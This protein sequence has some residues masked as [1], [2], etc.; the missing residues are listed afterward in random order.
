MTDHTDFPYTR[1]PDL[2]YAVVQASGPD[3]PRNDTASVAKLANGDLMVVWHK[4]RTGAQGSSD[5]GVCDIAT[6][7]SSDQGRTWDRER[8]LVKTAAGDNN[9]QAPALRKLRN[10][11]LLLVSLQGH[12]GGESSTMCLFRSTDDGETFLPEPPIWKRS[13]GQWLQ[14]GAPSLL[15]LQNRRLLLP[16]HGGVGHQGSQH[17]VVHCFYSD[18]GGQHWQRNVEALDLPMRGAMEASVAELPD[19]ELIMSLR[20][21]LGAVFLSRSLDGGESWALAQ[22]SGVKA[23][24]SCTC[25]RAIPGTDHLILL[26]NDSLYDPTHHHYGIR[27]PLSL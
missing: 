12:K 4:Y 27:S 19:G 5:F 9:V 25:L 17:N 24:E 14:G 2:T 8:I 23:P 16:F 6:K 3:N 7:R 13:P 26:W 22:T 20:T 10:G 18:D 21:Q 15:E 1:H 11:D